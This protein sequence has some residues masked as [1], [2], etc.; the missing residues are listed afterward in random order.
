MRSID[1]GHTCLDTN[2][3]QR[4]GIEEVIFAE[5]KSIEELV[6]ICQTCCRELGRVLVTRIKVD[7]RPLLERSVP[8]LSFSRSGRVA[9]FGGGMLSGVKSSDARPG[10]SK[11]GTAGPVAERHVSILTAGTSD[12]LVAEEAEATLQYFGLPCTRFNDVGI[13]GLHRLLSVIDSVRAADC[14]IVVAGMDGALAA[15]VSGLCKAPIIAV[16]TS[17]GYGAAF[18]GL[19][20][21][22]SMMVSCAPGVSVVNIDNGFGA[23]VSAKRILSCG[24]EGQGISDCLS[25]VSA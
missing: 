5:G 15:A 11:L 18:D 20:A 12:A 8:E 14:I 4:C 23:A 10:D 9:S 17:V 2:R 6:E 13:A 25:K 16:P 24:V 7:Q 3:E 21:L 22:L 19:A 1:L